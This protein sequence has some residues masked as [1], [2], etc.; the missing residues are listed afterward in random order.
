MKEKLKVVTSLIEVGFKRLPYIPRVSPILAY[1]CFLH[2]PPS[3]KLKDIFASIIIETKH[4]SHDS[5]NPL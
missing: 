5:L 4:L 3:L 2:N 1:E